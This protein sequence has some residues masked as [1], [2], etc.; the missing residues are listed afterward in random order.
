MVRTK[1]LSD[2][3]VRSKTALSGKLTEFAILIV[4]RE[5][6][7]QYLWVF[8]EPAAIRAGLSKNII[9]AL[10]QSHRPEG[11]IGRRTDHLR[12]LNRASAKAQR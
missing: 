8:H 5:W 11:M 3:L 1:A 12:F 2:Y 7:Q 6:T 4:A 9:A 10:A